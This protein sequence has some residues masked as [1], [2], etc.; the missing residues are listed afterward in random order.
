MAIFSFQKKKN[1]SK[2]I[3]NLKTILGV[4]VSL[5]III[6]ASY[7]YASSKKP[8]EITSYDVNIEVSEDNVLHITETITAYF[9]TSKHGIVRV[10]PLNGTLNRYD[11]DTSNYRAKVSNISV[12]E[13]FTKN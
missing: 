5:V 3:Q 7:I 10:I 13:N 8:Y 4:I 12:N 11:N 2:H 6:S 1:T 9:N